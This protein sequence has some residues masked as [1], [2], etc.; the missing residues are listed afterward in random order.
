M[1]QQLQLEYQAPTIQAEIGSIGF[2]YRRPPDMLA[3]SRIRLLDGCAA[4]PHVSLSRTAAGCP[5]STGAGSGRR[6]DQSHQAHIIAVIDPSA[7]A[8]KPMVRGPV[9]WDAIPA[10]AIERIIT[11]QRIDSS[12]AKMRP[13]NWFGVCSSSCELFSTLVTAIPTRRSEE[14]RVGKEC[15]SRW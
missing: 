5:F 10:A 2:T 15:R 9:Y 6:P 7:P 11:D 4:D 13:R 1:L 8:I 14:R 3:D 12:V